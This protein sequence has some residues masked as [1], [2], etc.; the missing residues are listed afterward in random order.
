MTIGWQPAKWLGKKAKRSTGRFP[1]GTVAFYGPDDRR[2][3]KVVAA[4]ILA[5]DTE[6]AE[7][8]RWIVETGDVRR[9]RAILAEVVAFLRAHGVESVSMPDRIIGC[10]HEEAI[11]YPQGEPCPRCPFWAGRDRWAGVRTSR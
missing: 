7:L 4:V 5:P 10:P 1:V 3:T 8:R 9:D 2:A 11:D 6:P